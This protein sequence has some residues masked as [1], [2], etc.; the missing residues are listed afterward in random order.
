M[1]PILNVVL[2]IKHLTN[3]I[4]PR[5]PMSRVRD[6]IAYSQVGTVTDDIHDP[7]KLL[8]SHY[9][10]DMDVDQSVISPPKRIQIKSNKSCRI[11]NTSRR[12]IIA[13]TFH[14]GKANP[15]YVCYN[16]EMTN[17]EQWQA[18]ARKELLVKLVVWMRMLPSAH[19]IFGL[20]LENYLEK[21]RRCG[22]VRRCVTRWRLWSFKSPFHSQA[23][24]SASYLQIKM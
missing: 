1:Y 8:F 23:S 13:R 12:S 17:R 11:F 4:L 7:S 9:H 2:G 19:A 21:I 14:W 20:Q 16:C 6:I 24:L 18:M 5:R 22:F 15:T 3:P 10:G